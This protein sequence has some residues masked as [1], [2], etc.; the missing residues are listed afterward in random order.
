MKY[1]AAHWGAYEIH[2]NALKSFSDDP[3]PSRIGKGWLS[4][5]RNE[6]SR[7]LK[8]ALRKGWL[9]GDGGANRCD[10]VFVEVSWEEAAQRVADE[11]TRV[12][13]TYGNG[14]IYG[15]S[16]GWASAGRFHHAQSQLKRLLNLTGGFV[17]ARET[18]SHAAGEV[19]IPHILGMSQGK[20]QDQMTSLGPYQ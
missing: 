20:Y 18:Y 2:D 5:S 6:Q 1:T 8:P 10:D 19:I 9:E 7:I 11:L 16:Y 17:S 14:S 13:K 4:A 15:G 12:S 3:E